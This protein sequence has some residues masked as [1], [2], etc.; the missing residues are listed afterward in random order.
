MWDK[1]KCIQGHKRKS[2]VLQKHKTAITNKQKADLLSTTFSKNSSKKLSEMLSSNKILP[3][4]NATAAKNES[5]EDINYNKPRTM[6][7]LK[8]KKYHSNRTRYN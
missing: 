8:A 7:E 5:D 2:R 6:S 4:N 3:S 1:V